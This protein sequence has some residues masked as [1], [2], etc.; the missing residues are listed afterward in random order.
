MQGLI[1]RLVRLDASHPELRRWRCPRAELR[2]RRPGGRG[3][4]ELRHAFERRGHEPLREHHRSAGSD[5]RPVNCST[6]SSRCRASTASRTSSLK[7]AF[8]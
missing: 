8:E 7:S 1:V 6:P 4:V 5:V 3:P 2:R